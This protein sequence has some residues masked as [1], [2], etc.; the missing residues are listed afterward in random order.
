MFVR[1][2]EKKDA[3]PASSATPFL[4][5]KGDYQFWCSDNE[6]DAV[7]CRSGSAT[8]KNSS[9]YVGIGN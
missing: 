5:Y 9:F 6:N 3:A 8:L 7:P 1:L 4:A 2:R